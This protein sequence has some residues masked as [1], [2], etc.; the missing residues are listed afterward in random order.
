MKLHK[1]IDDFQSVLETVGEDFQDNPENRIKF[2]V[3]DKIFQ[4]KVVSLQLELKIV[5]KC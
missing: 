4:K 1:R 3:Q 5:S 2:V